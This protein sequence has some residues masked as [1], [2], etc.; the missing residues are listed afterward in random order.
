MV[1]GAAMPGPPPGARGAM[2]LQIAAPGATPEQLQQWFLK[3][4]V[5]RE[6]VLYE[7]E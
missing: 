7:V 3:L 5:N 1:M 2:D 6:G 4:S